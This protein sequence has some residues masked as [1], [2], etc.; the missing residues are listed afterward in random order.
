MTD[1]QAKIAGLLKEK[2]SNAAIPEDAYENLLDSGI[3]DSF[4][5]VDLIDSLENLFGIQIDGDDIIPEN[6]ESI[7]A[8]ARLVEKSR[9]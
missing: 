3:I 8:I 6:F 4:D 2:K 7:D 9:P 5:I 1:I